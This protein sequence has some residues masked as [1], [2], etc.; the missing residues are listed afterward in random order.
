[1]YNERAYKRAIGFL[2]DRSK[3][4]SYGFYARKAREF[5][6]DIVES[7][8]ENLIDMARLRHENEQLK[9][10]LQSWKEVAS[11]ADSYMDE[12]ERLRERLYE[13][14]CLT[15]VV[16]MKESADCEF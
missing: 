1:M 15:G 7:H 6:T 16:R 11:R 2:N 10:S 4:I 14:S 3:V 5:L 8:E 12:N 9:K 13:I